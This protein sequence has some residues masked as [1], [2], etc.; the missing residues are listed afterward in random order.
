MA[1][2]PLK[3]LL[4]GVKCGNMGW[5]SLN[6]H[7]K[8]AHLI[9]NKTSYAYPTHLSPR[10]CYCR[11]PQADSFRSPEAQYFSRLS[12]SD[13]PASLEGHR[14]GNEGLFLVW[15]GRGGL[16]GFWWGWFGSGILHPNPGSLAFARLP[17]FRKQNTLVSILSRQVFHHNSHQF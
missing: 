11:H 12:I 16:L 7:F 1:L 8:F 4:P 5:G 3:R 14:V 13:L 17:A 9:R 15:A 6:D 10:N 2:H